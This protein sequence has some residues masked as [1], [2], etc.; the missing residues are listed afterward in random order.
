[1]NN[2]VR[3]IGE[4]VPPPS[5]YKFQKMKWIQINFAKNVQNIVNEIQLIILEYL[6]INDN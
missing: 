5:E 6:H 4:Y 3:R 2:S 1:M